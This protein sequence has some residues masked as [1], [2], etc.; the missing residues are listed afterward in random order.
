MADASWESYIMVLSKVQWSME[1]GMGAQRATAREKRAFDMLEPRVRACLE[2]LGF[3]VPTPPQEVAIPKVLAHQHVLVIAPTG[4]GKTE[5]AMLPIMSELVREKERAGIYALYI[6]PLRALN[7]DMLR[8]MRQW[9]QMLD[10]DI[11]VR[12]GDTTTSQRRRQALKPPDILITTPETLQIV[13]TGKRLRGHLEGVRY[14]VVD[15]VHELA[16]S[17]RGAQLSLALE[18]LT[19]LC[20]E[21]TRV[22]LSAT[23]G[24][25]QEVARFLAGVDRHIE[26]LDVSFTTHP[27]IRVSI[28]A[29]K[30]EDVKLASKLSCS[31]QL[32]S[33][34]RA[35]SEIVEHKTST[36]IFV[37]TRS[38]AEVLGSRFTRM[39]L[40]IGVHH[41]SLSRDVRVAAEEDFKQG[42]L[43]GLICTSSME[44]GVDIGAV[45]HVVQYSSPRE[46]SRLVQRVGRSGHSLDKTSEGTIICTCPDDVLESCV[47]VKMA[48]EGMLEHLTPPP[49]PMDVLANQICA[50]ALFKEMSLKELHALFRRA[51]LYRELTYEDVERVAAELAEHGLI[52]L[53]GDVVKRR[54]R[55]MHYFYDNLSMIPDERRYT[56]HD[57]VSRRAIGTLDEVFVA[58]IE[59][60][61]AV[62]ISKGEMWRIADID[63]EH[64]E[65]RVEPVS[66]EGDVP[67]WVGEEIPVP[68]A[69]AQ[70]VGK[71]RRRIADTLQQGK[72]LLEIASELFTDEHTLDEVAR[73]ISSQLKD[74]L[75]IP[76]HTTLTV[77]E[78]TDEEGHYIVVNACL[79]HRINE[80]LGRYIATMLSARH[81]ESIGVEVDPYRIRL[82]T[83]RGVHAEEVMAQLRDAKPEH[84]RP[85]LE[86]ALKG[87]NLFKWKFVAVAKR[88]GILGKDVRW[89]SIGIGR[90][91]EAYRGTVAYRE[92]LSEVMWDRL[93]IKGA[94]RAIDAI[95]TGEL[96]LIRQRASP[97]G[98]CGFG[99][100]YDLV[101]S[102]KADAVVLEA[103]KERILND[104]VLLVCVD[105]CTYHQRVQVARVPEDIK[106]P[107]CGS[108]F[109]AALKPWE[110]EVRELL[111]KS[112]RTRLREDEV[113][114]V[115]RAH[116]NSSLVRSYGKRAVVVL[117]ARGVGPETAARI[118]SH[119]MRGELDMYRAI[120]RAERTY[121]RTRRFWD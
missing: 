3:R 64:M 11:Q 20:G 75:V 107:V 61:H 14:V 93:D 4:S 82:K 91:I 105:C 86:L 85:V 68:Y 32:A 1:V 60:P 104:H 25:P 84:V 103:L 37:N 76:D 62:F 22:G 36:L 92:A 106:C 41:G 70:E 72:G 56:V 7:R 6:T 44:L 59:Q 100:R 30:K 109:V 112:K 115:K 69:V 101:A 102:T 113:A 5:S 47:I 13:L 38:S 17:K 8:R 114:K 119:P 73:V 108:T 121:A 21:F 18:R 88:F 15:E 9:A 71:L 97:M 46:V 12:H 2:A 74:H 53:E 95:R 78:H 63:H 99:A 10:I 55:C 54:R 120:L 48:R 43:K 34:V 19:L 42:R 79:G 51:Y 96:K 111:A 80:T 87:T 77:E 94:E 65:V 90:L 35:I 27:S 67:D 52:W 50:T 26:V 40:P 58:S 89:Q 118:L 110:G 45:D 49:M 39:G 29:L 83:P 16:S 23:V 33:H 57:V 81:G 31:P 28:P 117:A 66:G 98:A 116:R 24:N